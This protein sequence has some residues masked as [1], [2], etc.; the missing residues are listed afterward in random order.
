MIWYT[1][2]SS[3]LIGFISSVVQEEMSSVENEG[4]EILWWFEMC[5]RGVKYLFRALKQ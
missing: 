2:R 5:E 3:L 4:G 1:G